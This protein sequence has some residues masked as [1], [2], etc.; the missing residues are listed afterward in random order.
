MS[1]A[2]GRLRSIASMRRVR[3]G[4]DPDQVDDLLAAQ[5]QDIEQLRRA[6]EA[7]L[8]EARCAHRAIRECASQQP[9]TCHAWL[10][11]H[12]RRTSEQPPLS[13]PNRQERR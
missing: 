11:Y 5:G 6:L 2:S 3:D 7:A 12:G 1:T 13:D 4:L 8:D 10:A 9:A